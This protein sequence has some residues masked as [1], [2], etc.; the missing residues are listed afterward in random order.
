MRLFSGVTT[1]LPFLLVIFFSS[2]SNLAHSELPDLTATNDER[3]IANPSYVIGQYWFR[4]LNGSN[5]VID[6]PPAYDYLKETLSTILPQTSLHNKM[7]EMTLL[8]STQT[9]AFVIPG[10]HLFIYSDIMEMINSENML[11]GLLAHELSHLDLHHYERQQQHTSEEFHKNMLLIGAGIAAALAGAAPDASAALWMGGIA[12]QIDNSLIYSRAQEQQ[13]DRQG[14]QYLVDAGLN[15]HGMTELFQA[16]LKA[17]LGRPQLEFLS[18]HPLPQSRLADSLST[19]Q[20][21]S[22]LK[23]TKNSDFDYFRAT[24]IVYRATLADNPY[25]YL[26]QTL[27][28]SEVSNFAFALL[29]YLDNTPDKA[30]ASLNKI[31]KKNRFTNYLLALVLKAN[32]KI[33]QALAIASESL[34]LA[35][36]DIIF[37]ALY[38]ELSAQKPKDSYASYLYEKKILWHAKMDYYQS[39]RNIPLALNYKAKLEFSQ[40]KEKQAKRLLRRAEEDTFNQDQ[41]LIKE[42]R[43]YFDTITEVQR[44]ADLKDE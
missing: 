24:L 13:A 19:T 21:D 39:I 10:N 4:K 40:G 18:S 30:L 5:A 12:N 20:Q 35:P 17:A 6:F 16:F 44:E 29:Y 43:Y 14:R 38:S 28:R 8:N 9:N 3:S 41:R 32:K 26:T 2:L 25:E 34:N 27:K 37:N 42:T 15:P 36:N 7:V 33:N 1:K 22:I 23:N 11:Y 31:T